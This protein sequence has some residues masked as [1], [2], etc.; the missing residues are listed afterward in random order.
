MLW[1]KKKSF[2]DNRRRSWTDAKLFM[3]SVP[4]L[5]L[6]TLLLVINISAKLYQSFDSHDIQKY[7][8]SERSNTLQLKKLPSNRKTMKKHIKAMEIFKKNTHTSCKSAQTSQNTQ[9]CEGDK[10]MASKQSTHFAMAGV[11]NIRLGA[12]NWPSKDSSSARWTT[13]KN[14]KK[15][16][17]LELF[18]LQL[19]LLI[20]PSPLPFTIHQSNYLTDKQWQ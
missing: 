10:P 19:F 18:I 5:K 15:F 14:M 13:F 20:R 6:L 9:K 17:D 2:I 4:K 1:K 7:G 16:V 3:L 11:S 8:G 12:Q